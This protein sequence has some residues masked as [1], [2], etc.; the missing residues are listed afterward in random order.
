MTKWNWKE[1]TPLW[2]MLILVVEMT[3]L[4][5]LRTNAPAT[6]YVDVVTTDFRDPA[7]PVTMVDDVS[8][9]LPGI[10][11]IWIDTV[12]QWAMA[13]I[14]LAALLLSAW[15]VLLVRGT[16]KAARDANLGFKKSAER[17]LRAY[18]V[19]D[20]LEDETLGIGRIL[21]KPSWKNAGQT[22]TRNAV[23]GGWYMLTEDDLPADFSYSDDPNRD[24]GRFSLGPGCREEFSGPT[25]TEA[26]AIAASGKM[27]LYVWGWVEYNDV[28]EDTPRWRTEYCVRWIPQRGGGRLTALHGPHNGTDAECLKR[29][30]T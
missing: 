16:L 7:A 2:I 27:H 18:L 21:L 28:F 14:S 8:L 26:E 29:P 20:G 23:C 22:P 4:P 30:S 19:F 5:A 11:D 24:G 6:G 1:F 17:Q 13:I 12:P 25:I 15:A 3:F 9:P 10:P